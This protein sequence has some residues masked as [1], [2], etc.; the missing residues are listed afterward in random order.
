M[1]LEEIRK[2]RLDKLET[3]KKAG[4]NPYPAATSRTHSAAQAVAAFSELSQ[5]NQKIVLAGRVRSLR[6][7]GGSTF[8]HVEDGT[9]LIQIYFKKNH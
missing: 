5:A 2:I 9:G 4:F 7:H 8:A 1:S 6:E 3:V